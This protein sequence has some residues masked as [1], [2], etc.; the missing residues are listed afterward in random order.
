MPDPARTVFSP[1]GSPLA[2]IR[3][4]PLSEGSPTS[5]FQ[6]GTNVANTLIVLIQRSVIMKYKQLGRTA[7]KVSTICYGTW[8]FGGDWGTFEVTEAQGT[9]RHALDLGINFFDTAQAYGF[10][11]SERVLGL[12]LKDQIKK[13][14]DQIVI[15][16]KG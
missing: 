4:L 5:A 9:I 14:R 6:H 7:L 1:Q 2:I 12:A 10:G 16:T 8:Q 15:A 11:K 3:R 13:K